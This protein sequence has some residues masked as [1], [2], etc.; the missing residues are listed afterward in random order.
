MHAVFQVIKLIRVHQWSK[1]LLIFVPLIVS[2]QLENIILWRELLTAFFAFNFCASAGY[3]INDIVDLPRDQIH[4]IK[5]SRPLASGFFSINIAA[6]FAIFL[7]SISIYLGI[8]VGKVFCIAL[9]LY[10]LIAQAYTLKLKQVHIIDCIILSFLYMMRIIAGALAI[11][12][13]LSVWILSFSLFFFFSF[14]LLKRYSELLHHAPGS[15]TLF[16]RGY[17]KEDLP[18]VLN[19]GLPSALIS[20]LIIGLYINDEKIYSFYSEPKLLFLFLPILLIWVCSIWSR[21]IRGIEIN[22][23]ISFALSDKTSILIFLT[24]GLIFL[25]A[26]Y[27]EVTI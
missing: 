3:I 12:L 7:L 10:F 27:G 4:Q 17:V 9:I 18:L 24:S 16:G 22:D 13:D 19:M 2:P 11:S 1:N 21:A 8:L 6:S 15:N 5:R 25:L 20:I 26:R 23:P 14:A